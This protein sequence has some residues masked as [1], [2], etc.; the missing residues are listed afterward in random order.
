MKM[1]LYNIHTPAEVED[2]ITIPIPEKNKKEPSKLRR[3]KYGMYNIG[4]KFESMVCSTTSTA[5]N[6]N[7]VVSSVR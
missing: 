2:N 5:D 4:W 7:L 1:I 6:M 3:E